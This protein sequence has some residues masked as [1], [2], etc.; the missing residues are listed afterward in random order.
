M[1]INCSQAGIV[2][3]KQPRQ[4]I[5]DIKRAEFESMFL[6]MSVYCT[7]YELENTMEPMLNKIA[8]EKMKV[9]VAIAPY[10][11]RDT[12]REDLYTLVTRLAKESIRVCGRIGCH[13]L[14]VRPLFAGICKSDIWDKNRGYYLCY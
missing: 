14:V 3:I 10:L 9:A 12:K 7:G 1:V 8:A 5:L 13:Y 6:D 11:C 4:G 2:N